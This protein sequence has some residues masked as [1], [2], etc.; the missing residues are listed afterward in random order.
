MSVF[1][2][3]LNQVMQEK[4]MTAGMLALKAGLSPRMIQ[5]YKK[6]KSTPGTYN[7]NRL[8]AALGVTM[9]WLVGEEKE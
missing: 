9:E 2:E 7:L 6:G 8:A 5:I 3:R 4:N 1:A